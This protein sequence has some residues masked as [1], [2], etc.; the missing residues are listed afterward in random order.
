MIVENKIEVFHKLLV[1]NANKKKK[2]WWERYLRNSISFL[3]V[4]IP[5]IRGL[6]IT[7]HQE[8]KI[9]NL[10]LETQLG[11]VKKFMVRTFAEDKLAGILF[12]QLF[13]LKRE[14]YKS[15]V[16][17]IQELF[18]EEKIFDW[19]TCDW[20]CVRLLTPIVE[21]NDVES[22]K[23]ISSWKDAEFLWKARASAVAFAQ[24]KEKSKHMKAIDE[25]NRTLIKRNERFGKTS[26]GWLLREISR[27]DKTYVEKFISD[28]L[29][30]FTK[31]TINN[32]MKY[33][34]VEQRKKY[35][36]KLREL[37]LNEKQI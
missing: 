30:Y 17:L 14:N 10:S 18:D 4:G 6:L 8:N 27:D 9:E 11:I 12:V 34:E 33:F 32:S 24:V 35:L 16:L 36:K 22:V 25:I 26:V 2:D 5:E 21:S 15:I 31:E 28:Q 20:M 23:I 13:L 37:K 29:I 3:G 7:W 1:A 19:N